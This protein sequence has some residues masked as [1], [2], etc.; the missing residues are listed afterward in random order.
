VFATNIG[1]EHLVGLSGDSYRYGLSAGSVELTSAITITSVV[2]LG[3]GGLLVAT[4]LILFMSSRELIS[5]SSKSTVKVLNSLD[6]IIF[7][8]FIAFLMT[9]VFLVFLA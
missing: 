3:L 4:L 9:I 1:A 6:A 5:A 2:G 7:P 8:L